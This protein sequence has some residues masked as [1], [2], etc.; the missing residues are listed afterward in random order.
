MFQLKRSS[1]R[2]ISRRF[3]GTVFTLVIAIAVLLQIAR[4][5][6]PLVNDYRHVVSSELGKQ[7]GVVIEI[8]RIH[9]E[10]KGL[11]PSI[12][13]EDL[14]V[15]NTQFEPIFH[16]G[17]ASAELSII[18]SALQRRLEWRRIIFQDFETTIKQQDTGSW[19]IQGYGG[20][21]ANTSNQFNFDDPLDVFLF[22]RRVE[23]LDAALRF[24][25][26]TGEVSE[27]VVP[28]ISLENDRFFHRLVA[29]LSLD[30]VDG[31]EDHTDGESRQA[32]KF[33]L[34]GYGDPRDEAKFTA[35]GYLKLENIPASKVLNALSTT[36][37]DDVNDDGF[38]LDHNLDLELWF[39]GAP[40]FGLT[41]SGKVSFLSES[42]Q[43]L[44]GVRLPSSFTAGISGAWQQKQGWFLNLQDFDLNWMGERAPLDHVSLYGNGKKVGLRIPEIDI[45]YWAKSIHKSGLE[46]AEKIQEVIA[47][48]DLKGR[49]KN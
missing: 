2:V 35:S 39:K 42:E 32:L 36:K 8:G 43:A 21:T 18:D 4:Q 37:I 40:K 44:K 25:Y 49:L 45:G 34:E 33:V 28:R 47:D 1:L 48:L 29:D 3:W 10:W 26:V 17:D 13:L 9:A 27:I 5:A 31:L 23:I 41:I 46:N 19:K 14:R 38:D 6:F 30:N 11:R 20:G 15:L 7:L 12:H 24:S 22:G 16:V